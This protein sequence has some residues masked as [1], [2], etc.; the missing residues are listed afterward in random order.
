MPDETLKIHTGYVVTAL[1]VL[2]SAAISFNAWAVASMYERPT[3]KE[4]VKLIEVHAPY[5]ADQKF[6]LSTLER[7]ER[8]LDSLSQTTDTNA[9]AAIELKALVSKGI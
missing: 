6:I 5:K 9:K 3:E 8:K 2:L 7:I 4:A 1:G